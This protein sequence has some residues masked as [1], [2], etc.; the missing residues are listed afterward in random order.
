LALFASLWIY[1]QNYSSPF[2]EG[3]KREAENVVRR[4]H[5]GYNARQIDRFCDEAFACPGSTDMRGAWNSYV[6][7]VRECAGS[8]RTV[9]TSNIR[10]AVEPF[11][12]RATF[13]SSFEKGVATESFVLMDSPLKNGSLE[14]GPLKIMSYKVEINGERISTE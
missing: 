9:K 5:E 6:N 14:F 3:K 2:R 13:V 1:L 8:F 4:F 11:D 7:R 10:I 12:V